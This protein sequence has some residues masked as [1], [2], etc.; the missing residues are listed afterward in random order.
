MKHGVV[1]GV[2]LFVLV[3]G[4]PGPITYH[5]ST[6]RTGWNGLE[7]V[8]TASNV[9]PSTFGLVASTVLD[10]QVDTQPLVVANQKVAGTVYH[11]VAYVTT[12]SNTVYAIDGVSGTVIRS[13]N[14]GAPVTFPE[15][16]GNNAPNVGINGTGTIDVKKGTFYVVAYVQAA[17]GPQFQLHALDL[18]TLA[19]K[20]G[21]PVLVS[22][23]HRLTDGT[24]TPFNASVQRQ[25][26]ALLEASGNV[27]AAFGSF[28]DFSPDR[29]RGWILG[30]NAAS[31]APLAANFVTDTLATSPPA[32]NWTGQV[33]SNFFLASVWMSGYGPAADSDGNLYF[34]TGNGNPATYNN[35]QSLQESVI[36]VTPDLSTVLDVF[37]PSSWSGLDTADND[38]GSGGVLLLPDQ[39]GPEPHVAVA[40]G[41]DGRLFIL[42]RDNMGGMHS[43]D[44]PPNVSVGSCWCGPSY[45]EGADGVGRIVSSGGTTVQLWKFNPG[46]PPSLTLEGTSAAV[47]DGT[48]DPGFFT[49]VSSA[50]ISPGT[51][52]IWAIGRPGPASGNF[53]IKLFAFS[54]VPSGGVLNQLWSSVAGSWPNTGG[55]ANLV[56]TISGGRVYVASYKRLAIF[57]LVSAAPA[58]ACGGTLPLTEVPGSTC[59]D[60]GTGR[61]GRWKCVGPAANAVTCDTSASGVAEVCG[62]CEIPALPG[63][64]HGRGDKCFCN[65]PGLTSGILVCAPQGGLICCPCNSA[66]GCGPGSPSFQSPSQ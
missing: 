64:G 51:A 34:V 13:V 28:C 60:L 43:P 65:D 32:A 35:P 33:F 46:S 58:N 6:L 53:A 66:P 25:R 55:N 61:C 23:S 24:T 26:P 14:L 8:L 54:A 31:L 62:H 47:Q 50:L 1:G 38:I 17:T 18:E 9:S 11:A 7:G 3:C 59:K 41:K 42:N 10:D 27:Y 29:T 22:G 36:K 63:S 44:V 45:F 48:Q 21:S 39:G 57:G 49:S 15:S 40:A 5:Q 2:V 19:D 16:C 56:P 30:W 20:P 37:T 52:I 4:C 12:E